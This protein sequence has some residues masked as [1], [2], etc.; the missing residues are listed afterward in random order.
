M[1]DIILMIIPAAAD[2]STSLIADGRTS[3]SS[4]A[5]V[6]MLR[7]SII[8]QLFGGDSENP[9]SMLIG[10]PSRNDATVPITQKTPTVTKSSPIAIC[11]VI[12]KLAPVFLARV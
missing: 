1:P 9:R 3:G 4:V 7:S 12:T 10:S 8:Y 2:S 6:F 11:L 5:M